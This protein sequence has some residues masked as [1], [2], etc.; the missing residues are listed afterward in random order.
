MAINLF[1]DAA[2]KF[3]NGDYEGAYSAYQRAG[4]KCGIDTVRYNLLACEKKLGLCNKKVNQQNIATCWADV[5]FDSSTCVSRNFDKVYLINLPDQTEKRLKA[6]IQLLNMGIDFEL[7]Q[8]TD[9]R[10]GESYQQYIEYSNR[11]LGA[12]NTFPAFS[13][14]EIKRGKK[15]IESAGAIGYINTYIKLIKNAKKQGYQRILILEDDVLLADN[16]LSKLDTFTS[17]IDSD[18]KILQLGCSQYDWQGI[19]QQTSTANGFYYPRNLHTCGSFALA[20]DHTLFDKLISLLSCHE[21]PFDLLP[22][23]LLYEEHIGKCFVAYPNIV[24]PDVSGSSIRGSR[25]QYQHAKIMKWEINKFNYPLPKTSIS[26]LISSKNNLKYLKSFTRKESMPYDLRIFYMSQDG[27]RPV[28]NSEVL[29]GNNQQILSVDKDVTILESDFGVYIAPQEILTEKDL[30][31][32][33]EYSCGLTKQKSSCLQPLNTA[34]LSVVEGRVSVIIPTYKRLLNFAKALESVVTQDYENKEIL[35]VDDNG[36]DTEFSSAIAEMVAKYARDFPDVNIKLIQHSI[37]RNGSAARNSAIYAST[38]EYICFLDDDDIYLAGRLSKSIA[39]LKSLP[40]EEGAVYCGYINGG[41]RGIDKSRYLSGDLSDQL[42]TLEYQK[43]YLHTDTATY[44]RSAVIA[45]CGFD[46]SYRRHQDLEFN[47]RFFQHYEI[48][49]VKEALVHIRP[50]KP[51]VNNTVFNKNMFDIKN[52]FLSQFAPII[53]SYD[54][55]KKQRIYE[56]HWSEAIRFTDSKKTMRKQLQANLKNNELQMYLKL[57][58][59][60]Y[61]IQGSER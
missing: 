50:M 41:D 45:L 15:F 26:V 48:E 53:S 34:N 25:C 6:A 36:I 22:L 2:E 23:G 10:Q 31:N 20:L 61:K 54:D 56:A 5:E 24:M 58:K 59:R 43:H 7:V 14:L 13:E 21:A 51:P 38:G 52:K 46:E 16:F 8:A 28:H 49:C 37:N 44:K 18:W 27:I 29:E 32:Y 11:P 35:V 60:K 39:K 30:L 3:N 47:L 9:G 4:I 40:K 55:K 1:K 19:D 33:M 12:L 57:S 17:C 42:L